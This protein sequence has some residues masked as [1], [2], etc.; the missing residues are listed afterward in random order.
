ME[1]FLREGILFHNACQ[2]TYPIITVLHRFT[3]HAEDR[4]LDYYLAS[5]HNASAGSLLESKRN[6]PDPTCF[7]SLLLDSQ[8]GVTTCL[9]KFLI[10]QLISWT[11]IPSMIGQVI[12][13]CMC[14]FRW[15]KNSNSRLSVGTKSF[16]K[17][18]TCWLVNIVVY[19]QDTWTMTLWDW[20]L[21]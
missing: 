12:T 7:L 1:P 3:M 14:N 8:C 5:K 17:I 11:L 15:I 9:C 19:L 21:L 6:V 18:K 10:L 4:C 2:S 16:S 13:S 20:W